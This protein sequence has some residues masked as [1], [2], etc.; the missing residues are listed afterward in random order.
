[1]DTTRLA[2]LTPEDLKAVT[3]AMLAFT[4]EQRDRLEGQRFDR[5][6]NPIDEGRGIDHYENEHGECLVGCALDEGSP[7]KDDQAR[8]VGWDPD[9]I[10]AH[11]LGILSDLSDAGAFQ[12]PESV[13]ELLALGRAE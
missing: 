5:F 13:R 9:S 3:A 8:L 6:Y 7:L 11:G 12:T 2:D 4:D 10:E 1:M